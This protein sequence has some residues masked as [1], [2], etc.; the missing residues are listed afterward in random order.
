MEK[1][2]SKL[3][4]SFN[5]MVKTTFKIIE[6]LNTLEEY[7]SI[8]I[9]YITT[10]LRHTMNSTVPIID[11]EEEKLKDILYKKSQ[12]SNDNHKAMSKYVSDI[13][14]LSQEMRLKVIDLYNKQMGGLNVDTTITYRFIYSTGTA[15]S[16]Q[17]IY[18][19]GQETPEIP[20]LHSAEHK[21]PTLSD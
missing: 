4:A 10:K 6:L 9:G 11:A 3:L 19:Y 12:A 8:D 21:T 2:D 17:R 20:R 7:D 14:I 16:N 13:I 18:I 5:E 15:N 1:Y